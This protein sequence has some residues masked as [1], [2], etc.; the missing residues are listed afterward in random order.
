MHTQSA[1]EYWHRSGSLVHTDT[2]GR[3]DAEV[4]ANVRIY[5][6]GGTQHGPASFPPGR[7]SADNLLNPGDYRPF[8]RGLLDALD[9]WVRDGSEPPT[10]VYPRIDRGTLVDWS[11]QATG[12]PALPRVRYPEVIQ[13]PSALDVGPDFATKGIVSHE[14]PR[15]LGHYTV[16]V[17]KSDADGNDLGCLLP[18]EVAVPLATYTGWNLRRRDVG[19]EGMLASLAGSYIPLPATEA[20]RQ[21]SGDP[22]LSIEK[23]YGSFEAYRKRWEAER[24]RL[25]KGKYLLAE[26]GERLAASLEKVRPMFPHATGTR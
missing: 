3:R 10:S 9:A 13:R 17:P 22:R 16:L 5:A 21:A 19:A 18:L 26:D 8:L 2:P 6:F 20:A 25:V 4:P 7:G 15:I 14:P 11:Q 24:E 23:R 1:A 12:F